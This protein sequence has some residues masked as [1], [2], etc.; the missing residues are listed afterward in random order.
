MTMIDPKTNFMLLLDILC[1][2]PREMAACIG[3]DTTLISRWRTGKRRL[4]AGR[5]WAKKASCYFVEYDE[6]MQLGLLRPIIR[7]LYPNK[8]CHTQDALIACV[9]QF[10]LCPGQHE[11]EYRY[12]RYKLLCT[13][14]PGRIQLPK[15]L[16]PAET[17]KSESSQGRKKLM[18]AVM[19]CIGSISHSHTCPQHMIIVASSGLNRLAQLHPAFTTK[20]LERMDVLFRQGH[21]LSLVVDSAYRLEGSEQFRARFE[22]LHVGGYIRTHYC[23]NQQKPE[24]F[25]KSMIFTTQSGICVS[26]SL[27]GN[28][29]DRAQILTI[30]SHIAADKAFSMATKLCNQSP[31]NYQRIPCRSPLNHAHAP[32]PST[33]VARRVYCSSDMPLFGLVNASELSALCQ[34]TESECARAAGSFR[35]FV[36]NPAS[37]LSGSVRHIVC[38][39]EVERALLSGEAEIPELSNV[40]GRKVCIGPSQISF[41]LQRMLTM[42]DTR[43][44]YELAFLPR[45]AMDPLTFRMLVMEDCCAFGSGALGHYAATVNPQS[46]ANL[47]AYAEILWKHIP[48]GMKSR[49]VSTRAILELLARK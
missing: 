9:T 24:S 10:L 6:R 3:T 41:I 15:D 27:Q 26:I 40:L 7:A 45:H 5:P 47:F 28:S 38:Q 42:L 39:D 11:M 20:L 35:P 16:A 33:P 25:R 32:I 49:S 14:L 12:R 36:A 37:F 31:E 21:T 43:E 34:L 1:I 19:E 4:V 44:H 48:P 30:K 18:A 13:V 46:V 22:A 2:S 17:P 29:L 23:D 8:P